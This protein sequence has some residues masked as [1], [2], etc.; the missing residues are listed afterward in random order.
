MVLEDSVLFIIFVC[1]LRI[2]RGVFVFRSFLSRFAVCV[3]ILTY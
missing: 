3:H 2:F 1:V